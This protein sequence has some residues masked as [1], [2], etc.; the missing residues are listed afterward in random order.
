MPCQRAI[1]ASISRSAVATSSTQVV[2]RVAVH[3]HLA[4]DDAHAARLGGGEQRVDRRRVHGREDHRRG[5]AVGEQRIEEQRRGR[6]GVR[7]VGVARLGREGVRRQPVEQLGAVAR[8]HVEL[9]AVH[10]GVDEAGQDQPAAVVVALPVFAGR[11]GLDGDDAAAFDQ[12]P[13]VGA[14]AHRRRIDVAPGRRGAEIEQVAVDGDARRGVGAERHGSRGKAGWHANRVYTIGP[15]HVEP[16]D[17]EPSD[18]LLPPRRRRRGR[19]R[20][21]DPHRPRLAARGR[22][23]HR[24]QGRLQRRRLRRL[25]GGRRRARRGRRRPAHDVVGGLRLRTANACIQ[26]LPTL[27]GKALFTS[28]TCKSRRRRRCTRCSRRWSSATARNAASARP[29]S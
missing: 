2:G 3:Q 26:F 5:R 23:L 16:S 19:R 13:V 24:H 17:V 14:E 28:R 27:D 12:Q 21:A 9:R 15:T 18:P 22:A 7:R 4:G 8:D 29:A 1:S 11:L 6:L 20:G 10:V 25:H